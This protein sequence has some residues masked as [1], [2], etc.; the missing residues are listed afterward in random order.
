MRT[1]IFCFKL[2]IIFFLLKSNVL[3]SIKN[4]IIVNV[5]NQIITSY[6]LKNKIRT[7]LFLGGIELNQKNID[8]NKNLAVRSL[9]NYKIKISEVSKYNL[10]SDKKSINDHLIRVS[11]KFNTNVQGL[12]KIFISN[13]LDFDMYKKEIE[14]EYLWQ[15]LIFSL[16][17]KKIIVD[18]KEVNEELKKNYLTDK[19]IKEYELAEIELISE[20]IIKDQNKINE[21]QKQI[22][23]NGFK[24]TAVKYSVSPNAFDGGN[25]GWIS[26]KTLSAEVLKLLQKINPGEITEPIFKSN[27]ITIF[28]LVSLRSIKLNE[29]DLEKLKQKIIISK[30]NEQL[31][32]FSNNHLSLVKRQY[33]IEMK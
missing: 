25:I 18:E 17:G 11:S 31:N 7:S 4:E 33:L 14:T 23:L 3:A 22:A 28:K 1:A 9:I 2:F 24:D 26:E 19:G 21:V 10:K 15:N 16:F 27:T 32:L 29:K 5:G 30:K 6:E 8:N 20:G 13:S 12:K